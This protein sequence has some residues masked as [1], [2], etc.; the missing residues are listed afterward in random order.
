MKFQKN[1][2]KSFIKIVFDK[3]LK[4][5]YNEIVKIIRRKEIYME[6][7]RKFGLYFTYIWWGVGVLTLILFG[8]TILTHEKIGFFVFGGITGYILWAGMLTFPLVAV[9]Q[10]IVFIASMAGLISAVKYKCRED[11]INEKKKEFL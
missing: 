8:L 7:F 1:D 9:W 6:K 11:V 5:C 4:P 3:I 10:I 2:E